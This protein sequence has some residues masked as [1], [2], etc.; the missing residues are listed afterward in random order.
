M[1]TRYIIIIA[2]AA[3]TSKCTHI[4]HPFTFDDINQAAEGKKAHIALTNGSVFNG[5]NIQ[6]AHDSTSWLDFNTGNIQSI[7]TSQINNI[8]LKKSGRGALEGFG[9]GILSG[10]VT[11]ALIGFASGDD[12]PE[13]VFLLPMTAAE[14]ALTG[15]IVLLVG[16]EVYLVCQLERQ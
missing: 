9:I 1:K 13:A 11:G 10:A 3:F 12:D 2:L 14:K 8:V 16:L 4:R 15:G 7:A 6:I 5:K